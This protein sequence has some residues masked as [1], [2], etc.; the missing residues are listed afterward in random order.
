LAIKWFHQ[1]AEA[2][3]V[4]VQCT[5]A[6]LYCAGEVVEQNYTEAANWFRK[7]AEQDDA[8]AQSDLGIL[9]YKGQGVTQ[10]YTQAAKWL[11]K[12]AQQGHA[13]AQYSLGALY[14]IGHGVN[15]DF[16]EAAK[17][18]R[19]AADQGN[20]DAENNLGACYD[21]GNGVPQDFGEAVKL[22]R[23][24]AEKGQA[25][26]QAALAE[27]YDAGQS[28]TRDYI[29]AYK[30]AD[31]AAGQ[32]F[33]G[34]EVLRDTLAGKMTSEE[35][36]EGRRRSA[37]LIQSR[38]AAMEAN[39]GDD[40]PSGTSPSLLE[41]LLREPAEGGDAGAQIALASHYFAVQSHGEACRW[42]R[43]AADQ[44][45]ETA[46]FKLGTAYALGNGVPQDF[47]EAY[48]WLNLAAARGVGD[49]QPWRREL[50]KAMTKKQ[51]AE[52]Q[53]RS[54]L[55]MAN[56]EKRVESPE[57][58]FAQPE[59]I[60]NAIS[61]GSGF[62]IT[63]DG[64]LLTNSH[65]VDTASRLVVVTGQGRKPARLLKADKVNDL[66]VLKV[67]G[68]FDSLPLASSGK[69]RLGEA[70]FTIG[71]PDPDVQ[72]VEPKL[73]RGE[74]SS[75][76]GIQDDP[77]HFQIS[78]PVQPGNSGGPLVDMAGNVVGI[79]V[80]RLSDS[81]TF[82]RTGMLPQ[83]VNY[84]IKS[85]LVSTLLETLPEVA[86]KLKTVHLL[87]DRPFDEVVAEARASAVRIELY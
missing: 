32:S 71:F 83:R 63:E 57:R 84:A 4:E 56:R 61:C 55:F 65:V 47:V 75:L 76:A 26:S 9:Y 22:W 16:I 70:V 21:K 10:D 48:K 79:A 31:L 34:S 13:H 5:L 19:K 29:E 6:A 28:V 18:W 85:S 27:A 11:L 24:A 15:Q 46:Q 42:L 59:S 58:F 23:K 2:G 69:V 7:A 12:A 35:I 86:G 1:A 53:R 41:R 3:D 39:S 64:F 73:T 25:N 72:G 20:A 77:R 36:T 62:F 44:G 67:S 82:E 33:D 49:A 8:R 45:I 43:A 40:A 14:Y 17:W 50:A 81:A 68:T 51:I 52:G 80:A 37:A 74:I 66:A 54:A 87:K 78:V 30:W 60:G 38:V